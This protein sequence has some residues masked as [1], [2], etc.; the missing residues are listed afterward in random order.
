MSLPRGHT[1]RYIY[2]RIRGSW[3]KKIYAVV[4]PFIIMACLLL[5]VGKKKDQDQENNKNIF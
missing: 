1:E 4:I 5:A 2:K 3:G